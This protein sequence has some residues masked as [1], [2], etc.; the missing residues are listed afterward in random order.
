MIEII[1]FSRIT[2]YT[3]IFLKF[4]K[5]YR[6]YKRNLNVSIVR[7]YYSMRNITR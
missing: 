2:D 3:I 7:C 1:N 5:N 4:T 6:K